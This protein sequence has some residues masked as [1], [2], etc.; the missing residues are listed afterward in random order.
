MNNIIL[1]NDNNIADNQFT[2]P[3]LRKRCVEL[4]AVL[5]EMLH[6]EQGLIIDDNESAIGLYIT[7]LAAL[8]LEYAFCF[9][10]EWQALTTEQRNEISQCHMSIVKVKLLSVD[11]I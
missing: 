6:C 1:S 7:M 2:Y 5:S 11:N 8:E 10:S 4:A 3:D 9:A